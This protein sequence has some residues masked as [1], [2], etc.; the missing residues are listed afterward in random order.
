MSTAGND[1]RHDPP[2]SE[3]PLARPVSAATSTGSPASGMVHALAETLRASD[4]TPVD[5][6]SVLNQEQTAIA[7]RF[8]NLVRADPSRAWDTYCTIPESHGGRIVNVDLARL[9]CPEY[10]RRGDA[11]EAVRRARTLLTPATYRTAKAY[12][13]AVFGALLRSEPAENLVIFSSGGPASGK[14]MALMREVDSMTI[15]NDSPT[16]YHPITY[17]TSFADIARALKDIDLCGNR[18]IRIVFVECEFEDA[19]RSMLDRS[20]RPGVNLGRYISASRM[21]RLHYGARSTIFQ[22][23][24]ACVSGPLRAR[25]IEISCY[26]RSE[27]GGEVQKVSLEQMRQRGYP[28]IQELSHVADLILEERRRELPIDLYRAIHG[29]AHLSG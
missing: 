23:S 18:P 14:T 11:V 15:T 24:D 27:A 25:D 19:M 21:A 29:S 16:P 6:E 17:D 2:P 1:P 10:E 20:M 5:P 26:R 4:M 28:N 3:P 13:D 7:T 12:C 8:A 22:L 9:L